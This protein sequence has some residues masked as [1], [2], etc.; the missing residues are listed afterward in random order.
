[1]SKINDFRLSVFDKLPKKASKGIA[2][3]EIGEFNRNSKPWFHTL[4]TDSDEGSLMV[5]MISVGCYT[6][7]YK[8]LV[9]KSVITTA[10]KNLGL[11]PDNDKNN[12]EKKKATKKDTVKVIKID[13]EP[14]NDLKEGQKKGKRGRPKGSK[15]KNGS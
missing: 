15:N 12:D 4:L 14:P 7:E 8:D 2:I 11:G 10:K 3:V 5:F 1:M 13:E 9:V 6:D